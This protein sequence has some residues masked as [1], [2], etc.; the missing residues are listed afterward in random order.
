MVFILFGGGR[1]GGQGLYSTRLFVCILCLIVVIG[2]R[3]FSL[4]QVK[5]YV[6]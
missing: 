4:H 1:G 6:E 3:Y 5:I 2:F